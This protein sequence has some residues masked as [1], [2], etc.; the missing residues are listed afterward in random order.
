MSKR[1]CAEQPEGS[2][3]RGLRNREKLG[4]VEGF[5]NAVSPSLR[6]HLK[7]IIPLVRVGF[8]LSVLSIK[9]AKLQSA[10]D[11]VRHLPH[12][13]ASTGRDR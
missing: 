11:E 4:V 7:S 10:R 13:M 12:M 1:C 8:F 9:V 3:E 6:L 2:R 5:V